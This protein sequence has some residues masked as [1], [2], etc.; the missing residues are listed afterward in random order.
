M[1]IVTASISVGPSPAS[2]R[3]RAARAA[4]KTAST[5]LPSTVTPTNPYAAARSTGSTANCLSSGVEYA[6]WLFSSTNTTGSF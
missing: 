4:S 3:S 6:Y 1:R 5:S 2:A